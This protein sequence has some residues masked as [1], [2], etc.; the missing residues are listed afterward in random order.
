MVF[1]G[2]HRA[3]SRE[4]VAR[5]TRGSAVDGV[6][7][8]RFNFMTLI[9]QDNNDLMIPTKLRHLMAGLISDAQIRIDRDVAHGFPLRLTG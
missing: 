8:D 7:P 1:G 9:I 5:L 6:S 3:R 4:R 2:V